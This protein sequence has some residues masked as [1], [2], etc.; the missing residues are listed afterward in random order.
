MRK[1]RNKFLAFI[2]SLF[3][4]FSFLLPAYGAGFAVS[5]D[6]VV[7]SGNDASPLSPVSLVVE[8]S[9][10]SKKAYI[11]QTLSDGTG[12]YS[13][14]F[15]LPAGSY[16]AYLGGGTS[17]VLEDI[18][19]NDSP[20]SPGGGSGN[21]IT[22]QAYLSITDDA[23]RVIISGFY[24]VRSGDTVLSFLRRVAQANGISLEVEGGYVKSINGLA[25]K[26][27]GYPRSGWKYRVN[28]IYPMISAAD[29]VLQAG[30]R[31]EWVYTLDYT[32]DPDALGFEKPRDIT[33]V[34]PVKEET[35]QKYEELLK[36][37]KEG[38]KV[39]NGD[40]R[41][42]EKKAEEIKKELAANLVEAKERID[43]KGGSVGDKEAAVV[44][45][46][47]ALNRSREIS[48]KELKEDMYP[49]DADY[50][51]ISSVYDLKPDGI[52]FLK[53]VT[54][55]IRLPLF[56]D[57]SLDKLTPAFYDEKAKT[58]QP[59]PGVIDAE[60]GIAVFTTTHFTKFAVVE[61]KAEVKEEKQE[62]MT[63]LSYFA[64]LDDVPWAKEAIT[65]LVAKGIIKG[66][67]ENRFEPNRT[68]TRAELA[69]LLVRIKGGEKTEGRAVFRDVREGDWFYYEVNSA[70]QRGIIKGY[71]DG[72][73]LP[74]R[75]VSR[76][77]AAVMMAALI[78]GKEE[79]K[80]ELIFKDRDRIPAWA[81]DGVARMYAQGIING[82]PDG[83]FRGERSLTRAEAAVMIYRMLKRAS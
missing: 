31:V 46:P 71:P 67:G 5:G 51:I 35:R 80:I 39:L 22:G 55:I 8:K 26:K 83:T 43:E 14:S 12:S 69:S 28:G 48:I 20:S 4:S 54:I 23:G 30:D 40:K 13:F 27:P 42:D 44:V 32:R 57:V 47:D 36:E 79:G 21:E 66:V 38:I 2:I 81:R 17:A 76:K 78:S 37:V 63:N 77:E 6:N 58:W 74:R 56:P 65:D 70:Y 11:G 61:R 3:L 68:I 45:P 16:R 82:Y 75:E 19:G 15:S 18:E 10:G 1:M 72:T 52:R 64:D 60:E 29:Y 62:E 73:F 34:L 24:S 9:D 49:S 53:P 33:P 7:I 41:M 25:H 50:R 59:L